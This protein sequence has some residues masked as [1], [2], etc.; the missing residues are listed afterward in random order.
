[1]KRLMIANR[2]EIAIRIARSAADLGL[3]SVVVFSEDDA[4]SLHVKAGDQAVALTGQGAAPYL[5]AAQLVAAAVAAG[6]DAIHPGYGFLSESADF[7]RRCGEAGLVF[8]GPDPA[9]LAVF[10]D[11]AQARALAMQ[12]G[13]PVM[14]GTAH[15]TGLDEARGFFE[16]LAPGQAMMVKAIAGG[17]GRGMRPVFTLGEVDGA[18]ALCRSEAL[19]AF[20]RADV[21]VERLLLRARHIEVQVVGDGSGQ[22]SHLWER[23]CSLQRQRQKLIELAPAPCWPPRC[24]SACSTPRWRWPAP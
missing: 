23:E 15:A 1:M 22:V 5:D 7:A 11:K 10:G 2:G 24:A 20:G 8:V 6:C 9:T 14:A 19:Q 12:C 21:Y 4:L 17:G 13:V 18:W 3:A 16:A